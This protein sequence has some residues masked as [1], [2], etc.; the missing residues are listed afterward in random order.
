MSFESLPQG[1]GENHFNLLRLLAASSVIISHAWCI[2]GGLTAFD[3]LYGFIGFDLGSSAVIAF[4][5][6][7]GYFILLSFQRRQ[8]NAAFIVARIT[9][10]IPG[11]LVVSLISTF[12]MGALLTTFPL[13]SY[14]HSNSTWLYTLQ[15]ISIYRIQASTLPGV[16]AHNPMRGF[17]NGSLW[18][19]FYEVACYIGLFFA[20]ILG[21]LRGARFVWMLLAWAPVYL[22]ARYGPWTNLNY[23]AI[24]SLPFLI[25]MTAYHFRTRG[26][27]RG[28]AALA[29][30]VVAAALGF[31]HHGVEELW[32]AAVAY[33]VLWLG[34]AEAPALLA[35]NKVGDFS[36]GTYIYGFPVGQICAALIPGIGV[37]LLITLSLPIS[38]LCGALSW[39]VVEKPALE[40]RNIHFRRPRQTAG[41]I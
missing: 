41:A 7:S 8:S 20:G 19:L 22:A 14:F 27:L 39:H 17:I 31:E 23:F 1:H 13:S 3:P 40:L 10:I 36:Y 32:S 29:L 15:N 35:Y 33:G 25:G 28:W 26:M 18:T 12:I 34:F 24:L 16:F 37:P 30:L 21:F 9:R 5:A 6:I 11:L 4:F 38:I 2:A